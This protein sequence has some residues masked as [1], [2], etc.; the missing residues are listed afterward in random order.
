M[1]RFALGARAFVLTLPLLLSACWWDGSDATA[2]Y[3]V[4][5]TVSG[6]NVSG[7][8]LANGADT[9]SPAS[10]ATTFSFA[11]G[12]AA[13]GSY[14]VSVKTQPAGATCSVANG[15]GSVAAAA[16]TNVQVSCTPNMYSIGGSIS[17]LITAGLVLANG[18]DTVSPDAGA[19]TFAFGQTVAASAAYAV[20]VKAQPLDATC[21][22]SA[23]SGA[24][25]AAGVT[26]VQ[27][28][29]ATNAYKLGGTVAG[30]ASSGLL[31][32]NASDTMTVA[33]GAQ[34]FAFEN[35]V[36]E[37]ANYAITVQTQPAGTTCSVG[38]G[39]GTMGGA[40]VTTVQI[41]CAAN[42]HVLGGTI[43]GLG[44]AGLV[45]A[46]GG[47]TV[48]PAGGAKIF[49][50]PNA[51]AQGASYAVTVKTQPAAAT[52]SVS[53][54]GGTMGGAD[55]STVLVSCV[56]NAY[57]VGGTIT[58][59]G[60]NGLTLTNGADTVRPAAGAAGFAFATAVAQ[61]GSY[62]VTVTAQPAGS[63][64]TVLNGSGT[65]GAAPVTSIQVS[66]V[67]I[68][69]SIG[70]TI[71][72]LAGS[73]LVLANGTDTVSPPS[74]A[75]AFAFAGKVA[76][77]GSYAVAVMTQPA[78]ATCAVANGSGT[79][80]A[81][82]VGNVQVSCAANAYT[83]GG[84]ITGLTSSG[85]VL[86]NGN[87][88]VSPAAQATSFSLPT[89]VVQG[90]SYAVT[91]KTQPLGANCVVANGSGMVGAGNVGT[92]QVSCAANAYTV[93]GSITGLTSSGLVLANGSDTVSPAA[94]ATGFTLPTPVVQGGSYTVT[95]KTQPAGLQCSLINSTG[96]INGANVSNVAVACAALTHTLGGTVSG[97]PSNG[98]VLANGSDT[99]SPGAGALSFTFTLPVAE[100]GAYA[101]SVK[102]QPT[103]A[104]CSVG[105]GSGTMGTANVASVE[106]T[107]S[108]SAYKVGGTISGLTA[109]GLILANG[110]DTVSPAANATTFTFTQSVAFGGS[111]SVT[112]KQ[113]PTN[114]TCVVGGAFPATM[115]AGDVTNVAVTCAGTAAFTPLVG[116]ETC[117]QPYTQDGTGSSA[118]VYGS[119]GM[120]FD[121]AGNL[122]VIDGQTLRKITPAGVV[123]TIAGSTSGNGTQI[124]GTGPA[125]SFSNRTPGMGADSAGNL[126]V[127][128]WDAV[129]KVTQGGVVTTIAGSALV[130]GYVD[131]P[132]STARLYFPAG[133]AADSLGNVYVVDYDNHAI[134]KISAA[135]MV[136]TLAG[137]APPARVFGFVDGVG[138]AARFAIP[139]GLAIDAAGNLFVADLGNNA[140][141]KV[142]PAGGVTTLAGGG[143]LAPGYLDATGAAARFNGPQ[144]ISID[145][146]GN[147]YVSDAAQSLVRKVTPAGVVTTVAYT[148]TFIN[149]GHTAPSGAL[150]IPVANG[151][152]AVYVVN[153]VGVA[154]IPVGC[155][156]ETSP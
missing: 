104:T 27:I 125:A 67:P 123:T 52:C 77:G 151:G 147:L 153:S 96:T 74:G 70:G 144:D 98:L 1:I 131:G 15:S 64:C 82:N 121:A 81:G 73:G 3:T 156:I 114:L 95:V 106:V 31:L 136:T 41:T 57:S 40:D 60:A 102:T 100:G 37:G 139:W 10:G 124:D 59:L 16:V 13:G 143:Q 42:T 11:T 68:V 90:S 17:G 120:A 152:A 86:A 33:A 66:C 4:G 101:V 34:S 107:C 118:S 94:L 130:N 93:G 39:S 84:S 30:L 91:V 146:A 137:S 26:S 19:K 5:G 78:G 45:L 154:Y 138:A 63:V 23:G 54:G 6:L 62:A 113:Q 126:Y 128:D 12:V 115:G 58:G 110:T 22:V 75:T 44:S 149:S 65:V 145:G 148:D 51:V 76:Q 87:D 85:L 18:A 99:V 8:V 97:L 71:S 48:A 72:G 119:T 9:A 53:N 49:A 88:T 92:V 127:T 129:R 89:P 20:T 116:H 79:V 50:F 111:Y 24:V 140:I 117:T 69:Y 21:S 108:A 155:A 150:H 32:A 103:G 142:T 7:L 46:N 122:Y 43:A 25:G 14:A 28:A 35:P 56:A 38:N 80:G 135:G 105:A 29:C 112:V 61:G 133:I 55:V 36:A 132:G 109:S 2:A 141:R 83:V 134:R 47:D